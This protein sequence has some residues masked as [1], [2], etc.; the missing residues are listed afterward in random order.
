MRPAPFRSAYRSFFR[1]LQHLASRQRDDDTQAGF[2]LRVQRQ[3]AAV[4]FGDPAA[5]GQT[6]AGA[7]Y[8]FRS[9]QPLK[10]GERCAMVMKRYAGAIIGNAQQSFIVFL[11][12]VNDDRGSRPGLFQDIIEKALHQGGHHR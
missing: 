12:A 10:K 8:A 1:L 5:F 6:H 7:G 3:Y 11:D 9:V 4:K 2:V